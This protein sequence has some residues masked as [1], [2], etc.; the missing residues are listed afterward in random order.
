MSEVEGLR[1]SGRLDTV[2]CER[3]ERGTVVYREQSPHK[4]CGGGGEVWCMMMKS[5]QEDR[6]VGDSASPVN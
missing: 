2:V 3:P 6:G 5:R 1:G 4:G